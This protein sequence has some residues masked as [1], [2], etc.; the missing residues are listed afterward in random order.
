MNI[1]KT[2]WKLNDKNCIGRFSYKINKIKIKSPSDYDNVFSFDNKEPSI[3]RLYKGNK[4]EKKVI[5]FLIMKFR[6]HESFTFELCE[7]GKKLIV[8][9]IHVEIEEYTGNVI[10][11]LRHI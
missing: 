3:I 5:D 7:N 6:F 8:K 1:P 11:R 10:F 9:V 2:I 4:S